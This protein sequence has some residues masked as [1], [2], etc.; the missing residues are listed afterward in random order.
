ML[1]L[2]RQVFH[3]LIGIILVSLLYFDLINLKIL[4]YVFLFGLIIFFI[5]KKYKIKGIEWFLQRFDREIDLRGRGVLTYFIGV[6]L[7]LFLFERNIALASMMI[8]ALGDSF[9]HLG[10]YGSWLHPLNNLKYIEGV[11]IGIAI[12]TLGA[13]FFVPFKYAFF[14]SLFSMVLESLDV[15]I[16]NIE[17]DDNILIPLV[18]GVVMSLL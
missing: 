4:V 12:G 16:K 6:I 13:V 17:I 5:S 11:L 3:A 2:R 15:K 9:C 14:G 18:A 10:K 7:S 1:E 8:L